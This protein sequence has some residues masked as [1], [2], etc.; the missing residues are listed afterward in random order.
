MRDAG[1]QPNKIQEPKR[2][3]A[4]LKSYDDWGR[5]LETETVLDL[6]RRIQ[7]RSYDD[8]VLIAESMQ[9]RTLH[10]ICD[11]VFAHFPGVRLL[12]VAGPSSSGKTTFTKRLDIELRSLGLKPIS[13]SMDNYFINKADTPLDED[14]RPDFE[15]INTVDLPLFNQ[16]LADLIAGRPVQLPIFDFVTGTRA[17]ATVPCQMEEDNILL[18]EGIHALNPILTDAI[19][20]AQKRTIYVS[21]LTQ[22]NLDPLVPISS[23]DNRLLRRMIRDMRS[24]NTSPEET[25]YHWPAVRKGEGKNIFPF[26]EQA[27]FYFNS[28]LIYELPALRPLIDSRLQVVGP[29]SAVYGEA[30]RLL[31]FLQ[32]FIPAQ[33][34]CI[35]A[36][37]ILQEFLGNGCFDIE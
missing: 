6:N 37:S 15:N 33:P 34:R 16:H 5:L 2:L 25:L 7:D 28:S 19:P 22:L 26:Q 23:S 32:Y 27:D 3:Q 36:H 21:C 9:Q 1:F 8:L 4:I 20:K 13:I 35:P 29:D 30:Q 14:G 18:I 11:E 10:A 24:R 12:L 31:E 17:S